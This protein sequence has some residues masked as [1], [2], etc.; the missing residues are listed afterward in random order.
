MYAENLVNGA[1]GELGRTQSRSSLPYLHNSTWSRIVRI[2][3]R[4]GR[5]ISSDAGMWLLGLPL[6]LFIR[7]DFSLDFGW[8]RVAVGASA[9]V[10]L[11][12][13]TELVAILQWGRRHTG[14][15]AEVIV[16]TTSTAI[17]TL[18]FFGANLIIWNRL[19]PASVPLIAGFVAGGAQMAIRAL[20]RS[21]NDGRRR[22]DRNM[23]SPVLVFGAGEAGVQIITAMLRNPRSPFFPVAVLDDDPDKADFRIL[24]VPVVGSRHEIAAAASAF[25]AAALI[26]A[27][28]S[29]SPELVRD[30]SARA[31]NAGLAI[32]VLPPV[33]ELVGGS[34]GIE[35][36][37][38]LT[39]LDLLGRHEV[40]TD[41]AAIAGYLTGKRV[42]ITGAGGSI[43]SELCRQVA[44]F[45]PAELVMLDRD[46][47]AL[48]AVQL[49][50]YGRA[51]LDD[52]N[53]VVA[54][55]RDRSRLQDVFLRRLPDVVFHA[56]ALKH[57]TLL[58]M[59]PTEAVKTNVYGTQNVLDA[60]VA[61]GVKTLVNISTDKAANPTSVL[62]YSKR[63]AERLTSNVDVEGAAYLSVR[64]GNVLGSR[65][66]VLT[67]FRHQIAEGGPVTVSDPDVTRFFM[68]IEEAVQLVIQAGAIGRSSEVLVLDMGAPV[69]IAEV[70]ARLIEASGKDIGIEITGLRPGEK[71]H[72]EL[73]G[74]GEADE[75]PCH[76][77]ISH[78]R[79]P[80]LGIDVVS[81][82]GNPDQIA[83]KLPDLCEASFV[84][85][86]DLDQHRLLRTAEHA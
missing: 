47:S 36:I 15:F 68:T 1:G 9:A 46:E 27:T 59:H 58:E 76:P 51:R 71:L 64:F 62:G 79:A 82:V 61:A 49:T 2:A 50:L 7:L 85:V 69:G 40:Q 16:T 78:V 19:V 30:V 84:P 43:G 33:H 60:A 22:P 8:R 66:S 28:P 53:L 5:R 70:A 35:D 17:T 29:G 86:I 6:A 56:A 32:R 21:V 10:A 31:S 83:R 65:G 11:Q 34:I 14:S 18:V 55:I 75:R 39:E 54:D 13:I 48:H 81:A 26:I 67:V 37:R 45:A 3:T 74:E 42:L 57:L 12:A 20:H 73:F 41:L 72:E 80:S 52:P 23:A 77:L 24:G 44:R 38:P 4:V 63:V 25:D